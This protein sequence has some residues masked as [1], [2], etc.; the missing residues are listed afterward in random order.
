MST[1]SDPSGASRDAVFHAQ[2]VSYK[3]LLTTGIVVSV[4]GVA[5]IAVP[6]V[7]SVSTTIFIG[8]MLL[9]AGI[10]TGVSAFRA[11]TA[12]GGIFV[13]LLGLLM[14]VAGVGLLTEPES[15]TITL[16]FV[17]ALWLFASGIV[18]IVWAVRA[19]A[20]IDKAGWVI[21]S[22]GLSIVLG[23]LIA[24]HLP[25]SAAWAIGLLVGIELLSA[26]AALVFFALAVKNAPL[27]PA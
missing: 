11:A 16:T 27:V 21:A 3:V 15:G 9:F 2:D 18:R 4:L 26:G 20:A 23:I 6:S 5:A 10:A 7:A 13:G 8:L 22:G 24:N 12:A 19:R 17:L 14:I 25:S 1:V